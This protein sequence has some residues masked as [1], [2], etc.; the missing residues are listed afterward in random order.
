MLYKNKTKKFHQTIQPLSENP[1]IWDT[2]P[3]TNMSPKNQ[4]L[5]GV[6]PIYWNSPFLGDVLVSRGV[7][8]Y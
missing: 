3:K 5:E 2:P 8:N 6:F 4:W 1:A 7:T